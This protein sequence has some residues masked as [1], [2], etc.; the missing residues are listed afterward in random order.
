MLK[1]GVTRLGIATAYAPG[2]K[3]KVY[4]ALILAAPDDGRG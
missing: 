4:W 2:S 1:V 3:Y